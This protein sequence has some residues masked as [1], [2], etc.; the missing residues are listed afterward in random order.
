VMGY[1]VSYISPRD[2]GGALPPPLRGRDERCSLSGVGEVETSEARSQRNSESLRVKPPPPTPPRRGEGR[3]DS[4]L[5]CLH[6]AA[7]R[8]R[9]APSPQGAGLS[10]VSQ[11]LE[12]ES[13]IPSCML[14]FQVHR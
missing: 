12:K 3:R 1:S 14:S 10:H 8:R 7:S 5:L 11:K 9:R 13:I 2:D 4:S 6:A